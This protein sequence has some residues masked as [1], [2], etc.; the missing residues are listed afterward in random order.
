MHDETPQAHQKTHIKRFL[1][2][3]QKIFSFPTNHPTISYHLEIV[4]PQDKL[5]VEYWI[6][7]SPRHPTSKPRTLVRGQQK[8]IPKKP[9]APNSACP[10]LSGNSE[11][12]TLSPPSS[13]PPNCH[14]GPP[15]SSRPT[16]CPIGEP[17]ST[18]HRHCED[19]DLSRF[20]GVHRETWQSQTTHT[21]SSLTPTPSSLSLCLR[22]EAEGSTVPTAS[23]RETA[24]PIGRIPELNLQSKIY[25]IK[26]LAP[27]LSF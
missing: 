24:R 9:Q 3:I 11:L 27:P 10:D 1:K 2:K 14:P 4:Y 5:N 20:I 21:L 8:Q 18:P 23:P 19:P 25:N 22:Y 15:L 17:G 16:A 13:R 26:S 7:F 6:L 12:K